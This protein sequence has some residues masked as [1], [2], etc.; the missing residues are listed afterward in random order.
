MTTPPT[1][2]AG[3]APLLC[4]RFPARAAA[5][6]D[7][8]QE[9]QAALVTQGL[10]E[11]VVRDVVLAVDEACQNIVRHAYGGKGEGDILV[12]LRREGE[13]LVALLRD[14]A[15]PAGPDVIRDRE[16]D[17]ERIGGLGVHLMRTVM[18]EVALLAP[19]SGR[20]NVLRMV[21][22]IT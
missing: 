12:E 6:K 1:S 13:Q 16:P 7:I 4:G 20:G 2:P 14:F 19:D 17:P 11:A 8:R 21:K 3:P 5:L 18:D 15:E 10:G 9:V 22:R